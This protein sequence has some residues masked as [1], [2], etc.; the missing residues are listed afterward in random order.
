M[1]KIT[2]IAGALSNFMK[3]APIIYARQK[4]QAEGT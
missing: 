3:I 4:A 2:L 1:K